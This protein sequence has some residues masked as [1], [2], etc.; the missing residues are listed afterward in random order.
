ATVAREASESSGVW[1]AE[2]S[3][4][5]A[6]R[7]EALAN[8]NTELQ[9]LLARQAALLEERQRAE[10]SLQAL[11]PLLDAKRKR[12]WWTPA[13]WRA[14]VN[15]SAARR[16]Q[17]IEAKLIAAMEALTELDVCWGKTRRQLSALE[18]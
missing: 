12:R 3:R 4:L 18:A 15:G 7:R 11:Q 1:Q 13:W 14:L 10:I 8:C 17:E 5:D 6:V 16:A 2:L 9:K